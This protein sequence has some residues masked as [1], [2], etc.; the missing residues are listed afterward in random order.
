MVEYRVVKNGRIIKA[1][2]HWGWVQQLLT[3][4]EIV[5]AGKKELKAKSETKELKQKPQTKARGRKSKDSG[6][7]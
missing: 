6:S 5:E 3:G 1:R 7:D 4:G 2:G